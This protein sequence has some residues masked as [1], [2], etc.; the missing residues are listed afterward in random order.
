MRM[1]LDGSLARR[2]MADKKDESSPDLDALEGGWD[3]SDRTSDEPDLSKLDEG[4]LDELFPEE[5]EPDEEED[6]EPPLPDERLDPEAYA[7]AQKAREER[8]V[9]RQK[10]KK[11][12]LEAKRARQRARAAEAKQ[13]Q[14]QKQKPKKDKARER[15][16][17][18]A[19]A[20]AKE[21]RDAR[22][23]AS[24]RESDAEIEPVSSGDEDDA[25]V[26]KK[27]ATAKR[28][29]IENRSTQWKLLAVVVVV[30]LAA[31]AFAAAMAR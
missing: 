14:K 25:P 19:K 23:A 21:A 3:E 16:R 10:K 1:G 4:W 29:R 31:A 17:A 6:E 24:P 9:A 11:A 13:K 28:A 8:A 26:A 27:T 2:L 15:E 18:K 22:G 20:K 12:K 30:F 5:D 7:A